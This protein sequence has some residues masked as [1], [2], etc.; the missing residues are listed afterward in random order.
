MA[1][2]D[3]FELD[4]AEAL[5]AYAE[6]APTQVGPTELARHFATAYPHR[7]TLFGPWRPAEVLRLACLLLLA[8]SLLAAV[9]GGTI[10]VG[11]QLERRSLVVLPQV[12]SPSPSP[13]SPSPASPSPASPSPAADADAA[14]VADLAAVMNDPYDAAKVAA[15]YSPGAVIHETTANLTQT[16]LDEIGARIRYF[17]DRKFA[18]VVTSAPIRQGD[19]VAAFH[20]YGAGGDLS[21]LA[22]VVYQLKDGKVLNQWVYPTE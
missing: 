12:A 2:R 18:A 1:E 6:D 11:S 21:S 20:K 16:G 4:V 19:F 14:L 3:R 17:N 10:L 5:R 13:A 9:V 15:L 7:R 8:V 22:L